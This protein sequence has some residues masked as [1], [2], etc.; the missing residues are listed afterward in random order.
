MSGTGIEQIARPSVITTVRVPWE[1]AKWARARH[2]NYSHILVEQLRKLQSSSGMSA[3]QE[4]ADYLFRTD[5]YE[6]RQFGVEPERFIK[7][8][9]YSDNITINEYIGKSLDIAAIPKKIE[10]MC[11]RGYILSEEKKKPEYLLKQRL[12]LLRKYVKITNINHEMLKEH[13]AEKFLPARLKVE[14][15][16]NEYN[17]REKAKQSEQEVTKPFVP[18]EEVATHMQEDISDH[19]D[20][21][22][23]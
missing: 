4:Q 1:L 12:D 15:L 19:N 8:D 7:E 14:Q 2:V 11:D 3:E 17:E 13:I 5:P 22:K 18:A 9:R 20:I 10:Q 21:I 6:I 23:N 16:K